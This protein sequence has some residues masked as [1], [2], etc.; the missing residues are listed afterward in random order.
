MPLCMLN[1]QIAPNWHIQ[2]AAKWG[3]VQQ[4]TGLDVQCMKQKSVKKM[5]TKIPISK[6]NLNTKKVRFG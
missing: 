2:L 1:R 6:F 5:K 3:Q 4:K